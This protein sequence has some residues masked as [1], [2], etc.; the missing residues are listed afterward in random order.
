MTWADLEEYAR[1]NQDFLEWVRAQMKAG[2]TA[3]AAAA[4]YTLPAK[5]VGYTN[6]PDRVKLNVGVIYDELKK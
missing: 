1:F 3:E 5:Y 6:N 4:E 2:K